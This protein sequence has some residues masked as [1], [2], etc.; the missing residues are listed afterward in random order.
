MEPTSR[1]RSSKRINDLMDLRMISEKNQVK[2]IY[3]VQKLD[4]G[5]NRKLIK[6][7]VKRR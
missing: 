5:K 2:A 3:R 1:E 7:K 6:E 4:D